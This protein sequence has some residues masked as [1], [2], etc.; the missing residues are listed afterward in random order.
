M[1]SRLKNNIVILFCTSLLFIG[2][3]SHF[4]SLWYIEVF[5]DVGFDSILYTLFSD[6]SG[7]DSGQLQKFLYEALIPS[8]AVT[9]I[10]AFV[11]FVVTKR[12]IAVKVGKKIKFFLY[13]FNKVFSAV[14]SLVLSLSLIFSAASRVDM[15]RY[16]KYMFSESTAFIEEN[17]V[18]PATTKIIFPK[19]KQNLIIIYLESMETSFLSSEYEGGNDVNPIPELCELAENNLNFSHNETVGGFSSL[20]GGVWT[21][22]A[23]VS[24]TAGIPLKIPLNISGNEYGQEFFLPGITSLMDILDKNGYNQ[25]LMVGSDANF[26]NRRQYYSQHSLNTIYDL[27]TARQDGIVNPTYYTWWGIEDLYLFEYAKKELLTMSEADKPFAFQMLTV[28]THH[29]GGYVCEYCQNEF[30]EQY[31]NVLACSSR[32][33]YDFIEWLQK[34]EFYENTTVIISGD[35]PTMDAEYISR[36]IPNGYNRKVYNCFINAL[37]KTENS[38]NREFCSLDMF[39]TILSAIGC[40]IEGERLGL[41]TNLFSSKP[42]LCE[43]LGTSVLNEELNKKSDYYDK[44]FVGIDF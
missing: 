32:Q 13:P 2:F 35:H 14:V 19:E 31:E 23:I 30:E 12:R 44:E 28:D 29:V 21:V 1:K 33:V 15:L 37:S 10:V 40:E 7:V 42:T 25:A 18:N 39:P 41:G 22:G 17:Y 43:K 6:L 26:G 3:L 34:Q 27:Y 16:L 5:G 38:K 36:N 9:I 4:S 8:V 20:T 11:L 24:M